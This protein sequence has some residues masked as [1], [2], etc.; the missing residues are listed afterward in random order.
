MFIHRSNLAN[1]AVCRLVRL[2]GVHTGMCS[3]LGWWWQTQDYGVGMWCTY[4]NMV[5]HTSVLLI[6]LQL[7]CDMGP[8]LIIVDNFPNC[9]KWSWLYWDWKCLNRASSFQVVSDVVWPMCSTGLLLLAQTTELTPA[10]MPKRDC[11]LF[12]SACDMCANSVVT[13]PRKQIF[14]LVEKG[15]L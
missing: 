8:T 4:W 9:T 7:T 15:V 10:A 3:L 1:K 12:F 14:S 6:W 13:L 2:C 11:H 5:P